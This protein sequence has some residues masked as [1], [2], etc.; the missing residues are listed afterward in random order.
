MAQVRQDNVQIKLEIDGSQSRTE[1]D[2]LTRKAQ[3]LQD[4][5]KGLKKGSQE[6]IDQNKE[7]SQVKARMEELRAEIGLTSLTSAQLK[8][9][10]N[11]LNREL[12]NL[13]P[14]TESFLN[15]AQELANVDA[16]LAQVRA[17]AKGVKDE[18]GNAGSGISGFITK[19]AGFAGI[20]IGVQAVVGSLKQLGS[21]SIDAAIKGSDSISDMEKSLNLTTA[22]A[23]ALRT[24]LEGIDTRTS[25]QN[26]EGIAVAAG[27]LGI[28]KD[29]AV[30]FTQSVDQAVV[31]LGDEFSGGVEDVNKSLGGLQKLFKETA[32]VSPA[33]AITKIGSAVNALGA[34]GTATGPVIADFAARIGQLGDLAPQITQTLGLGAA[35]QELGLS[36]EISAGGLSN[37]L[38]TAAKDTDGFGKQIGLTSKEFK[39]LINSDP[40][41]VILRLAASLK[42]ASE[43]DVVS[44]L[45]K[46]GIKSQEATKVI[47]LLAN[48]TDTVRAKQALASTEYEKGTSLL[49]EFAKKNTNAA[50]EVAKAEKGFAQSRQELGEKLIPVY[51][52]ALQTFGFFIN[53]LKALPGFLNENRGVL[54]G[55]VVAVATLNA[56]QIQLTATTLYNTAVTKGKIL[57]DE[58]AAFATGK[59]TAA[60]R[61]LNITLAANPIGVV[62]AAAALLIGAF[63]TLYERSA[64]VREVVAGLGAAFTQLGKNIKE[65]FLLQL[66][67][68]SDIVT[69]IFSGDLT[70]IKAG[71]AKVGESVVKQY[72]AL[73]NGVAGAYNQG[74]A[75]REQQEQAATQQKQKAQQ[76][77]KLEDVKKQAQQEAAAAATADLEALKA[78]EANIKAALALVAA[79]SAEEL[80]LKKL[81]I[82]TKRDIDLLGEKKTEGDKKV[83]RAE[84]LR[85]LRQLQDEYDKKTKD[86]AD[87]RAKEQAEVEKKI[88]DLKAGLLTDET[89]KKIQQL[90]AAAEKEKATAKG[91]AEQIAEQR[92]LIEQKLAVDVA[93]ERQK[94]ALKQG[95][96]ALD[97]EKRNN[98]LIKDEWE[99][100]AAELRTSAASESLKILDTDTRAAEKRRLI[101]AKLQQDLVALERDRVAQQQEIAERIAAIDDNI[102]LARISRRRQQSAD[103]S[104]ERAKA[105]ADEQAVRK[106]ALDRQY[107]EDFF[108]QGLN[109]EQKLAIMRQYLQDKENL[110]NEFADRSQERYTAGVS[111]GLEI[112][113]TALQTVADF[114][115]IA[116]DKELAKLD[117]D[118]KQRL[119]KLD[120]EYKAGTISKDA[121]EAQKSSIETSYDEKTRAVKK[122]A[123]EKEK[124]AN[125][126]QAVIAG[127]LAVLKA[128]GPFTP[129]GALTAIASVAAVAKIIATPI[130]EFEKGGFFG[131]TS[132]AVQRGASQAWHGVKHYAAGG[133]I[134][135]TAG[136]AGVG[137]RHSGGGI[138]M[139][140]GATGEHLGEWEK[141]EPY[142]IL[143][144]DTYANNKHLV[145]ELIDTSLYRGGAPVRPRPGYFEDGGVSGGALPAAPAGGTAASQEL[146]QVV[147]ETRDA[148]LALPSRQRIAWGQDDTANVE[149]ALAER[150]DDRNAGAVR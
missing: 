148:V 20:Q 112:Q 34:D 41:E 7:L 130:P 114:Q 60:Q 68:I 135:A 133:R 55:L 58:A 106:A 70:K 99:R 62:V 53:V 123:A 149:D 57:W 32:N 139:V 27:Q 128:G 28:A 127:V 108:Q 24:Q 59:W 40:N 8:A 64:K 86:A 48:Q 124:V 72:T 22:E 51:L 80:R 75:E 131:R 143:S 11:Q 52:Y 134:N 140:D 35:F 90:E 79:G 30:A 31:A 125:I 47:S 67:G 29:E 104:L 83:I 122:E 136:V 36:A 39:D 94:L 74:Y 110:E 129:T 121:Y 50:A 103:F 81:E 14:N 89:E 105:D 1:L 87:K 16:R 101:Q 78:R 115:K 9:M 45:D 141:G 23:K 19:A 142:M 88:A 109:T 138:R 77:K 107:A 10:S 54:L 92:K 126:A 12:A 66:G 69:G 100:R 120:A 111:M 4:G 84:A 76:Q 118:K 61:L 144:R 91:T 42:G 21:E 137:Q 95:E 82:T 63:I 119:A 116:S 85:D 117:K 15:K 26:L 96:E 37:I 5:F 49:D 43:T 65:N 97:I 71:L 2:N 46:L 146:V 25:Q 132:R 3:V 150:A 93:A 73:G 13:T 6:Y 33:E 113:A 145:D 102:A 18:L 44:T 38:L 98:A 147:R 17:E 56:A